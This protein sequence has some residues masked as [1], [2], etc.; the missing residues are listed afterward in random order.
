MCLELG[1][2]TETQQNEKGVRDH[3]LQEYQSVGSSCVCAHVLNICSMF[4]ARTCAH[5]HLEVSGIHHHPPSFST[6]VSDA[7][8]LN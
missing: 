4:V 6:S 3:S 8:P 7:V 5:V 2:P 1:W